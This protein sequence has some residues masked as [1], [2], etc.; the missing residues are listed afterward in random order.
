MR[1]MVPIAIFV[2]FWPCNFVKTTFEIDDNQDLVKVEDFFM[3]IIIT[4]KSG[5]LKPPPSPHLCTPLECPANGR[6]AGSQWV[7]VQESI[8]WKFQSEVWQVCLYAFHILAWIDKGVIPLHKNLLCSSIHV[9]RRCQ[10][11]SYIDCPWYGAVAIVPLMQA[12]QLHWKN[13]PRKF[14]Q[15]CVVRNATL[16]CYSFP[17]KQRLLLSLVSRPI[18]SFSA[19]NIEK[20]GMGLGRS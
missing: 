14:C 10:P 12:W 7:G 15:V 13:V 17:S 8:Q 20:L 3:P 19:W 5:G 1:D 6:D 9:A 2:H 11:C 16:S 18:L 4:Q